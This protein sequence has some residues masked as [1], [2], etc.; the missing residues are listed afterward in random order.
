MS[1]LLHALQQ[2]ELVFP[3]PR[4]SLIII[5]RPCVEVEVEGVIS[6]GVTS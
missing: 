5:F 3:K 6:D 2:S 1:Q 4:E